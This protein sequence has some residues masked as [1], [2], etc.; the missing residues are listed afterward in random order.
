MT[1]RDGNISELALRPEM[2]PSVTR[3]VAARYPQLPKPIRW[4]S[5]AN[6]YRNE[7]PQRGRNREFWQL[8][9]DLFGETGE[10][11][12]LEILQLAMELMIAFQPPKDSWSLA[13][14]HR[15]LINAVLDSLD[16]DSSRQTD[17]VRTMDKFHK[18]DSKTFDD[19]LVGY[20]LSAKQAHSIRNFLVCENV[21][22]VIEQFPSVADHVAV[23]EL[24]QTIDD[25]KKLDYSDVVRFDASLMRGFDYYDGVVFEVFDHH[26]DNNRALFG[27]GCYDGLADIFGVKDSISA[28]GFAPG[29]ETMKLFL[30]S[31]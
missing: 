31:R 4:F 6:F 11:G 22:R 17:V 10:R 7:R 1:D 24:Q 5:I 18:L 21:E 27:G 29:D 28:V 8:N 9:V 14:N 20:G 12:L 15:G 2:T 25:L 13:L 3:M 23:M 30:E 26:P 19:I 16:I